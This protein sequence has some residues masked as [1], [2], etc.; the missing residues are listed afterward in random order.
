MNTPRRM[1]WLSMW[2]LVAAVLALGPSACQPA[3]ASGATAYPAATVTA[4][5]GSGPDPAVLAAAAQTA[6]AAAQG[7]PVPA[8]PI[9]NPSALR[10]IALVNEWRIASG[11]WPLAPND[12][13]QG[14]AETHAAYLASLPALPDAAGQQLDASGA[15]AAARAAATGWPTYNGDAVV[16]EVIYAGPGVDAALDE[17]G[18]APDSETALD[19]RYREIGAAAVPYQDGVL[20]VAILGSRPDVLPALLDP[21]S[22]LL[23]L[24]SERTSP[25]AGEWMPAPTSVQI[26]PSVPIA[27]QWQ[28]WEPTIAVPPT[29]EPFNVFYT[30]GSQTVSVYVNPRLDIV[31]LPSTLSI[32]DTALGTPVA[33][34]TPTNLP[35]RVI[36]FTPSPTY[37]PP[38]IYLL[39]DEAQMTI[40]NNSGSPIDLTDLE[41]ISSGGITL[42]GTDR[43]GETLTAPLYAFPHGYCLQ[44]MGANLPDPGRAPE[45]AV[46][47]GV[48]YL[49]PV[50]LFWMLFD[51]EVRIGDQVVGTCTAG[52]SPCELELPE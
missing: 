40:L 45:C 33:T 37:G 25:P 10:L 3:P 52:V 19:A 48:I 29:Q 21:D 6:Q 36:T 14:L 27:G 1:R 41:I 16:G 24:T 32:N 43:Q 5:S 30:D 26:S 35:I 47:D 8:R 50:N 15:D 17:W 44:V 39:F 49:N 4:R 28:G 46:R 31:W 2:C 23:Y 22:W 11:T 42:K 51:F 20:V 13:L 38:R 7:A 18:D 9:F 34:P 12:A